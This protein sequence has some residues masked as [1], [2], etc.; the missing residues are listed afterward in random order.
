MVRPFGMRTP[1]LLGGILLRKHLAS[2]SSSV[3]PYFRLG[4]YVGD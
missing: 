3:P 4:D 1:K 2:H